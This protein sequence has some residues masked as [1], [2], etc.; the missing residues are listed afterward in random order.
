MSSKNQDQV[1]LRLSADAELRN[2]TDC[3][4]YP[5]SEAETIEAL[6]WL[7]WARTVTIRTAQA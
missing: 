4:M 1:Q 7:W 5:V 3:L 6:T 2:E